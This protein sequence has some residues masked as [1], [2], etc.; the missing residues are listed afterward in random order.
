MYIVCFVRGNSHFCFTEHA[1]LFHLT[2]VTYTFQ[3][4]VESVSCLT[5]LRDRQVDIHYIAEES[6]KHSEEEDDLLLVP[7]TVPRERAASTAICCQTAA[8]RNRSELHLNLGTSASLNV[9]AAGLGAVRRN[10]MSSSSTSPSLSLVQ[11]VHPSVDVL[12]DAHHPKLISNNV[13]H[14][15]RL[16]LN[17]KRK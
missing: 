3:C 13:A 8:E 6:Q 17:Y 14:Q 11:L 12:L 4:F 15:V 5:W 7:P 2:M 9:A 10:R 16:R 1:L